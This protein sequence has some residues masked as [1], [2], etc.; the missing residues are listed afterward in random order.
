MLGSSHSEV[1]F[2]FDHHGHDVRD[3]RTG[4]APLNDKK[5]FAKQERGTFEYTC[6]AK[7]VVVR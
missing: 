5:I 3:G 1:L 6:H 4:T 7:I 2:Q